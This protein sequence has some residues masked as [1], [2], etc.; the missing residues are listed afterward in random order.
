MNNQITSKEILN[1][2]DKSLLLVRLS[3]PTLKSGDL[4]RD[5]L[6]NT[7]HVKEISH[8]KFKKNIPKWYF[9]TPEYCLEGSSLDVGDYLTIYSPDYDNK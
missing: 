8:Y 2:G 9:E 4:C 7:F 3:N 6:G 5:N 1:L